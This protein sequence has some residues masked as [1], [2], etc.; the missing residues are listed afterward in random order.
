MAELPHYLQQR[1]SSV[2]RQYCTV[3]WRWWSALPSVCSSCFCFLLYA[4]VVV[5]DAD[6]AESAADGDDDAEQGRSG[7]SPGGG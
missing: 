4:V 7:W 1:W 5:A 3:H 6:V 2:D